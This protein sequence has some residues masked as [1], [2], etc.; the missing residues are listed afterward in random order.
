MTLNLSKSVVALGACL[1]LALL[2]G[3]AAPSS[4]SADTAQAP[5]AAAP[6]AVQ[7]QDVAVGLY[8]IAAAS[9][10]A[11]FLSLIHI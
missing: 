11:L 9:P 7:R 4:G 10:S 8:E 2:A 6:A 1:S 3:C 5:S